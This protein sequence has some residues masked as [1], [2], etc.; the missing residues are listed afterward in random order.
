LYICKGWRNQPFSYYY[1][2]NREYSVL[3]Y[4][5]L[6][7]KDTKYIITKYTLHITAYGFLRVRRFPPPIK[8]TNKQM[9]LIQYPI[10]L[11]WYF[12]LMHSYIFWL[13]DTMFPLLVDSRA[14]YLCKNFTRFWNI[15]YYLIKIQNILLQNTHYTFLLKKNS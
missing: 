8:L 7:D 3:K 13:W 1:T 4:T 15:Q 12:V 5:V 9:T 14:C 10:L 6:F 2:R 11:Y